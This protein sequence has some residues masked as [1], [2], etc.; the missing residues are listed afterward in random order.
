MSAAFKGIRVLLPEWK[1]MMVRAR[2]SFVMRT[3][4]PKKK[5][6]TYYYAI[7]FNAFFPAPR[8]FTIQPSSEGAVIK[9]ASAVWMGVLT[10]PLFL[11]YVSTSTSYIILKP[12]SRSMFRSIYF[13]TTNTTTMMTNDDY[14]VGA[15]YKGTAGKR[16]RVQ[17]TA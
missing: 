17:D 7:H 16:G 4:F 1:V 15:I 14:A 6:T 13:K 11:L 10:L 3:F 9:L 8:L 2:C 12:C 5:P